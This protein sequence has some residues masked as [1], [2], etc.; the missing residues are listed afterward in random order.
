LLPHGGLHEGPYLPSTSTNPF[1]LLLF[2]LHLVELEQRM[3][4]RFKRWHVGRRANFLLA[5]LANGARAAGGTPALVSSLA[6]PATAS[7]S[8]KVEE[9]RKE[10]KTLTWGWRTFSLNCVTKFSFQH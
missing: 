10:K 2:P 4:E 8:P 3:Q 7:W 6:I 5:D 1:I 9:N